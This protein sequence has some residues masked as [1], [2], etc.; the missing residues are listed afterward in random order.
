MIEVIKNKSC[1]TLK[2]IS[3][4]EIPLEINPEDIVTGAVK[5]VQGNWETTTRPVPE[6]SEDKKDETEDRIRFYTVNNDGRVISD[7]K[8]NYAGYKPYYRTIMASAGVDNEFR[9]LKYATTT[10]N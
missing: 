1:G 2:N 9:G 10:E 7:N 3:G 6:L 8:H 4:K 5:W